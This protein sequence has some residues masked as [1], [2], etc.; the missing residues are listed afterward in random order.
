MHSCSCALPR[1]VFVPWCGERATCI[2][3]QRRNHLLSTVPG[4]WF[5]SRVELASVSAKGPAFNFNFNFI[6]APAKKMG[7]DTETPF[8][9]TRKPHADSISNQQGGR[10]VLCTSVVLHG[11]HSLLCFQVFFWLSLGQ[12]KA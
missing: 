12:C 3:C 4:Q 1:L 5:W 2:L 6:T 9:F 10:E 11:L 7:A 8:L